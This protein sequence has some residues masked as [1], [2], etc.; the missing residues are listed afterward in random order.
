MIEFLVPFEH[1][2]AKGCPQVRLILYAAITDIPEICGGRHPE[3]IAHRQLT[4]YEATKLAECLGNRF[5]VSANNSFPRLTSKVKE[6]CGILEINGSRLSVANLQFAKEVHSLY[7]SLHLSASCIMCLYFKFE[8]ILASPIF[9]TI[10]APQYWNYDLEKMIENVPSKQRSRVHYIINS[11]CRY[12]QNACRTHYENIS[13]CYQ[14]GEKSPLPLKCV[15][16]S[17][18]ANAFK[19][20]PVD[21]VI[22][23][24]LKAGFSSFKFEGRENSSPPLSLAFLTSLLTSRV[25]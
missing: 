16:P 25:N 21:H 10:C 5:Q 17:S 12:D 1:E 22:K 19:K 18:V 13:L 2:L 4:L 24:L 3:D 15:L 23:V 7:P 8:H 6:L 11:A 20:L 14:L 9:H